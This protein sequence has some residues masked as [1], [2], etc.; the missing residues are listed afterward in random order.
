MTASASA[1]SQVQHSELV[2][3]LP[4]HVEDPLPDWLGEEGFPNLVLS[5]LQ[6]MLCFSLEIFKLH[7]NVFS[8]VGENS[9]N[10][11]PF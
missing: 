7:T 6:M 2:P 10:S 3:E 4:D 5:K 1:L 8:A 11:S 9:H